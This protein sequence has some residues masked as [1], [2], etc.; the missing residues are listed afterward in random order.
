M[1]RR[2][3]HIYKACKVCHSPYKV[4]HKVCQK[5]CNQVC[6]LKFSLQ[7]SLQAFYRL[8]THYNRDITYF[9]YLLIKEKKIKYSFG[10]FL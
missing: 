7:A 4:C 6:K 10:G 3:W 8:F 2:G 5:A 1:L 9:T